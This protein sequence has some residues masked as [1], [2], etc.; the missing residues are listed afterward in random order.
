MALILDKTHTGVT[1]V[2]AS[3]ETLTTGYTN[4]NLVDD[5]GNT[6]E[7]PYLVIDS[8]IIDKIRK[9]VKLYVNTYKDTSARAN[10]LS[11]IKSEIKSIDGDEELYNTYFSIEELQE[12]NIFKAAYNF[13]QTE[14][15][16]SWKSDEV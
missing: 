3:G 14:Y 10:K 9:F 15:Y 1:S 11:P 13:I 4:L 2:D 16:E 6:H 12:G 8:L 5:F 7:H